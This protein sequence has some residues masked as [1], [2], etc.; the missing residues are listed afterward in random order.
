M[1]IKRWDTCG[2]EAL[3]NAVGGKIVGMSGEE[4]IYDKE[5]PT[6]NSS[7]IIV[8]RKVDEIPGLVQTY[9]DYKEELERTIY[10]GQ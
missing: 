10:T 5:G 3:L 2:T 6:L 1:G 9:N 8:I 4:Y 7:G